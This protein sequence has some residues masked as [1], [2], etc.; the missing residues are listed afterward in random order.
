MFCKLS[1]IIKHWPL[2]T[3]RSLFTKKLQFVF[4]YGTC[5]A[6]SGCYC[7][8]GEQ[9]G[10]CASCFDYLYHYEC[11]M[12]FEIKLKPLNIV[13]CC[14]YLTRICLKSK[15]LVVFTSNY[16]LYLVDN[17]HLLLGLVCLMHAQADTGVVQGTIVRLGW[18]KLIIIV[19]CECY[20]LEYPLNEGLKPPIPIH[21]ITL[22]F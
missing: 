15:I 2:K 12:L 19:L 9:C 18:V 7:C 20:L 3:C 14:L 4:Y 13:L 8:S 22:R 17:L 16:N 1:L 11:K 6:M 21:L 10:P 5:I